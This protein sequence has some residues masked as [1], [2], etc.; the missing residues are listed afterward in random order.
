MEGSRTLC[1]YEAFSPEAAHEEMRAPGRL[2]LA[3]LL[4]GLVAGCRIRGDTC[5]LGLMLGFD[6]VLLPGIACEETFVLLDGSFMLCFYEA[7]L[8]EDVHEG[9]SALFGR[10]ACAW[11][12]R[13]RPAGC[14][15]RA[16]ARTLGLMFVFDDVL[17]PGIAFEETFVLLD[18]LLTF[19]FYEAF[20]LK[21]AHELMRALFGRL[22]CI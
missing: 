6:V 19:G 9:T 16:D 12:L 11:L 21:D 8:L 20:S 17:L 2:A 15:R 3:R 7:L 13:G 18:G 22:A 5:A 1:F 10:L 14:R 4:R